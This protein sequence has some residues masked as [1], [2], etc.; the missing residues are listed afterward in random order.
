[1]RGRPGQ[2]VNTRT[3]SSEV[4]RPDNDVSIANARPEVPDDQETTDQKPGQT[5]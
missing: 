4:E 3:E 5:G 2:A 1:M